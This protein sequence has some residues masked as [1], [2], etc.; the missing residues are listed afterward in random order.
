[1]F[2]KRKKKEEDSVKFKTENYKMKDNYNKD[3]LVIANLEYVMSAYV[4]FSPIVK[5]TKQRYIFEKI[6]E[7][8]K[9]RYREVFTGFIAD[10][11][12]S[13]FDLPY[14]VNIKPMDKVL[15][16]VAETIPKYSLLLAIDEINS[17]QK[18]KVKVKVRNKK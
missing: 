9:I 7:D 16:K 1:M 4:D 6:E 3:D 2:G 11:E 17:I 14:V 15:D 13:Y 10:T 8:G 12:S 5:T 18:V